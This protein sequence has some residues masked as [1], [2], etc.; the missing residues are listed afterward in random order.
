[1][2]SHLTRAAPFG[3]VVGFAGLMTLGLSIYCWVSF[4]RAFGIE[5]P[6][7]RAKAI[8]FLWKPGTATLLAAIGL[9]VITRRMLANVDMSKPND[10]NRQK[11][12]F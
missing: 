8:G 4:F 11:I 7:M 5:D 10:P 9:F 1:M 2:D 12:R 6:E 3:C